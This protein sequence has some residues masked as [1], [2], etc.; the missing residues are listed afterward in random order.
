VRAGGERPEREISLLLDLFVASQRL[1][2]LLSHALV[3]AP[4]RSDEHAVYTALRVLGPRSSTELARMLAMPQTTMSD[5]VRTMM[6]RG[7]ARRVPHQRDRRSYLVELT[8]AG[9][10][11]QR[12]TRR[13]FLEAARRMEGLLAVPADEARRALH[14]LDDAAAAALEELYADSVERAG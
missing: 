14:A 2:L 6:D 1:R 3:D 13:R 8:P 10:T 9:E 4:L 7:H 11:A 5:Y 12:D